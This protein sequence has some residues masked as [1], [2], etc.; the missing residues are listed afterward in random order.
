MKRLILTIIII[1]SNCYI[2]FSQ[3]EV[4]DCGGD[5]SRQGLFIGGGLG[6]GTLN[7]Y[8]NINVNY[9]NDYLISPSIPN[10]KVG[11]F[12]NDKLLISLL[13]PGAVY[14]VN[15]SDRVAESVQLNLQY[16]LNKNLWVASGVGVA[17]DIPTFYTVKDLKFK[18]FYAGFPSVSVSTG[19]EI[20]RTNTYS[21]DLQYRFYYGNTSIEGNN[22]KAISNMMIVGFNWYKSKSISL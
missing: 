22:R 9:S 17:F 1:L 10:L 18:E 19:Y 20:Y 15:G 21:I 12:V 14:K 6:I 13:Q 5:I 2:C 8:N 4:C 7:M 16:W 11:Y 3:S